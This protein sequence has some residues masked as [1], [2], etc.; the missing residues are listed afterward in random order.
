MNYN[1]IRLEHS[2]AIERTV[3]EIIEEVIDVDECVSTETWLAVKARILAL[4]AEI[5]EQEVQHDH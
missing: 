3:D 1:D 5:A 2:E 4:L